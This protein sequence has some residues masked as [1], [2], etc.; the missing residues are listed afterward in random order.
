MRAEASRLA[1]TALA[2]FATFAGFVGREAGAPALGGDTTL[3]MPN[4]LIEVRVHTPWP[5]AVKGWVPIYVELANL[6][7]SRRNIRVDAHNSGW[8]SSVQIATGATLDPGER[9]HLELCAPAVG[10]WQD[11]YRVFA[12]VSGDDALQIDSECGTLGT[13]NAYHPVLVV[14]ATPPTSGALLTWSAEISSI[15]INSRTHGSTSTPVNDDIPFGFATWD[16]LPANAAAYTSLDL[17]VV[18]ATSGLPPTERLEPMLSWV[19]GGGTLMITGPNALELAQQAPSIAPWLEARF[20]ADFNDTRGWGMGLGR[21]FVASMTWPPQHA[22]LAREGQAPLDLDLE[23]SLVR[24]LCYAGGRFSTVPSQHGERV[25][26][27]QPEIPGLGAIPHRVFA[28]LLILFAIVI[29]PINFYVIK[30]TKRPVLL[31]VSIPAIALVTSIALLAYGV[32][33]QGLDIKTGSN[34]MAM[35]DQRTHR[36]AS[37]EKRLI[38]AGSAPSHGL[39]PALGTAVH[40]SGPFNDS[41]KRTYSITLDGGLQLEGEFLPTRSTTSH[42]L[43]NEQAERARVDVAR[44]GESYAITNN[45]GVALELFVLR[46]ASGAYFELASTLQAGAQAELAALDAVNGRTRGLDLLRHPFAATVAVAENHPDAELAPACYAAR[47]AS[48]AFGDACGLELNE[49][50]GVHHLWGVLALDDE[51][52]R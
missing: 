23:Q 13:P 16:D 24:A 51:V 43:T 14:G 47:I 33:F 38:F 31:L 7:A 48:N 40:G 32:F 19:R 42:V 1:L 29:G 2:V 28:A 10:Q 6:G 44:A 12:R 50:V 27:S 3:H 25:A 41:N 9:A 5:S 35:L 20:A 11:T 18:D 8:N 36:A 34:S 49:M 26:G 30:R 37:V 15:A 21:V 4:S 52:W 45:L 39:Q 22:T 46:D 17:V